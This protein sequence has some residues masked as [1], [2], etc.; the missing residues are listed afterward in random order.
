MD[1]SVSPK[2]ETWFL[3]VCHHISNAVYALYRRLRGPRGQSEGA[4]K[5]STPLWL[6]PRSGPHIEYASL[7][8]YSTC[9]LQFNYKRKARSVNGGNNPRN[10]H[11]GTTSSGLT[12]TPKVTHCNRSVD[13]A[14]R[15]RPSRRHGRNTILPLPLV[16]RCVIPV[17]CRK[18]SGEVNISHEN[19][20][21][22]VWIYDGI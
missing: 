11:F 9:L 19:T 16:L 14:H 15:H 3:R 5:I 18:T 21:M 8:A 7:A 10:L 17:V 4:W 22:L 12:P 13:R 6:D 20:T 2:D 1:S